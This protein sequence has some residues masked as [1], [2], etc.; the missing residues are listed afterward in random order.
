MYMNIYNLHITD[1][2]Y[3][4]SVSLNIFSNAHIK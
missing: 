1:I 2:L 4:N 3:M